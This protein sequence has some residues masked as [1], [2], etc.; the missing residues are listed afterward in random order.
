MKEVLTRRY[1]RLLEE[2]EPLP[3]LILVDGG[4]GQISAA[5]EALTALGIADKV[6]LLGLAER[7]EDI[8]RPNDPLPLYVDKKSETQRVLQHLREE[9]HRFG[10][11]HHRKLRSKGTIK[12]ELTK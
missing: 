12:T 11:T 2:K 4:K 9:A 8:Y 1:S 5:L 7:L 10:I 3:D 6:S